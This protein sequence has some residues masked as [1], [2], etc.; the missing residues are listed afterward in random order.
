MASFMNAWARAFQSQAKHII[1]HIASVLVR[2]ASV[3][4][5][6]FVFYLQ[7]ALI[8]CDYIGPFILQVNSCSSGIPCA[9][10]LYMARYHEPKTE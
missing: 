7:L 5:H 8:L 10:G 9:E 2:K 1:P 3:S 6:L 4:F